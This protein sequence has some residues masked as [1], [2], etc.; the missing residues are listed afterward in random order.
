MTGPVAPSLPAHTA[1]TAVLE[2]RLDEAIAA[3]DF[4]TA[5]QLDI[6]L[7]REFG[8]SRTLDRS[9]GPEFG[10]PEGDGAVPDTGRVLSYGTATDSTG[11]IWLAKTG[12]DLKVRVYRSQD[13]GV[14][15]DELFWFSHGTDIPQLEMVFGPGDSAF[16]YVFYLNGVSA[17]DLWVVRVRLDT[18][19]YESFP[20]AVGGDTI[21][22]FSVAADRDAHHY[23]YCIYANEMRDGRTGSFTRSL[24]FAK[25]W[26]VS[27]PWWNCWD[28]EIVHATGSAVHCAWR[29]ALT[30]RE[31]HFESNRHY[32]RLTRWWT[33]RLVSGS[34]DN[35][36]DPVVAQGDTGGEWNSVTW[37]AYTV[38]RRDTSDLDIAFSYS[39]DGAWN[40]NRNI[41]LGQ[42]FVDECYPDLVRVDGD[43]NGHVHLC[44]TGGQRSGPGKTRVFW[45][46]ANTLDPDYWSVPVRMSDL[47]ANG[48]YEGCRPRVVAPPGA[49]HSWPGVFYSLHH[50]DHA[51]GLRF[52][53]LWLGVGGDAGRRRPSPE[54][55][56]REKVVGLSVPAVCREGA[57][58]SATL[59]A[60]GRVRVAVYDA[61]GRLERTLFSGWLGTGTHR[62]EWDGAGASG[63]PARSGTYFVRVETGDLAE[64]A[65]F[66]LLR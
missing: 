7:S 21:N 13:L 20:V 25:T 31:I 3:Q 37:V 34:G 5:K 14:S 28:P 24:D 36:F 2:R 45:R 50:P 55:G 57:R 48:L 60:A 11:A 40:W 62:F 63:R 38:A 26:E 22:D 42:G 61:T 58:F 64:G 65:R 49:P 54:E 16:L 30:G 17:G 4:E 8:L 10:L 43:E 56:S 47:R 19:V 66:R 33:Y 35:C 1:E 53:A 29:Y 41:S 44:Y 46:A 32:G 39:T 15:W 51:E 9:D 52:S 12:P 59:G 23:I 27:Q 18:L 6:E